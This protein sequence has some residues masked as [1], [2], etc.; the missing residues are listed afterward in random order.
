M[1]TME[2]FFLCA[3]FWLTVI[4]V[5]NY[6]CITLLHIWFHYKAWMCLCP[7][8]A[9]HFV[10]EPPHQ[11]CKANRTFCV[12]TVLSHCSKIK[13]NKKSL[14]TTQMVV[15]VLLKLGSSTRGVGVWGFCIVDLNG[16]SWCTLLDRDLWFCAWNLLQCRIILTE[17]KRKDS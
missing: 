5:Q 13:K 17:G 12:N 1:G 3:Y 15:C 4:Y 2:A 14:S 6:P 10:H 7:A 11:C 8:R 9:S 16:S